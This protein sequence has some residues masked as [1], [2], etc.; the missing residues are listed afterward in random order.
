MYT[1]TNTVEYIDKSFNW[2][3][4]A[5]REI[6]VR[7]EDRLIQLLTEINKSTSKILDRYGKGDHESWQAIAGQTG[8][9]GFSSQMVAQAAEIAHLAQTFVD[10]AHTVTSNRTDEAHS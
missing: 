9:F 7:S 3:S 2:P 10:V 4:E 1:N 8:G 6:A 5:V